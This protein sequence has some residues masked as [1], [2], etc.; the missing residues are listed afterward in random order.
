[1]AN[2]RA[3]EDPDEAKP[4]LSNLWGRMIVNFGHVIMRSMKKQR[5]GKTGSPR[6]ISQEVVAE[7]LTERI[8]IASSA[9]R[10][11][12]PPRRRQRNYRE[13]D[14]SVHTFLSPTLGTF[15]R[16]QRSR[17]G[18]QRV[19]EKPDAKYVNGLRS[20]KKIAPIVGAKNSTRLDRPGRM[21][22]QDL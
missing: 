16:R 14:E 15:E 21:V 6:G 22:E 11:A 4:A 5:Q 1:M 20:N 9:K 10:G 8:C 2:I 12:K 3:K 7:K 13:L 19:V 18:K 17:E